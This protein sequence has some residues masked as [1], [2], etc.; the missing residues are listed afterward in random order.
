MGDNSAIQWTDA[1]WNPITGCTK[2]SPGCAYC[3]AERVDH[4]YDHDKV[5]KLSWALSA[6]RGGRPVTLH[7]DRLDQPLRWKRPRMVFVNSMSDLFHE[8]VPERFIAQV[9]G[10]MAKASQHTFQ[11]L[12]KRPERALELMAGAE[13]VEGVAYYAPEVLQGTLMPWPLGNVWVGVSVENQ[14]W[15]SRLDV[16]AQIPA[17]V[18]FVSAE[19]LLGPL[20]LRP[21]LPNPTFG[22]SVRSYVDAAGVERNAT[23]GDPVNALD[24]VI[25]GG[26][27]GGPSGRRLVHPAGEGLLRVPWRKAAWV[28]G[29]CDQAT[30]AGVPFFFKQWG[31]ATAKSGGA[32]LD[33]RE[34]K[35]MPETERVPA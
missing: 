31:G 32:M 18:R 11:I 22:G 12:T 33:G 7:P 23:G 26:E 19:P 27:S 10:T 16:L 15:T 17:A 21:W 20:D 25:V 30:G 2:V 5:G 29:L 3:Y 14:R 9:F 4:H 13:F 8:D 24:W 34:W 1:T 35:Q 6:A 28:R